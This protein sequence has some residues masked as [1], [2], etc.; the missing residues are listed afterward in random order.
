MSQFP[1]P[2]GAYPVLKALGCDYRKL[3]RVLSR[4]YEDLQWADRW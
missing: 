1:D 3:G 2:S 4:G